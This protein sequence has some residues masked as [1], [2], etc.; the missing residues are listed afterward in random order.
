[1]LS[2]HELAQALLAG[3]DVRIVMQKDGEG[4]SYSPFADL[5]QAHYRPHNVWDGW[6]YDDPHDDAVPCIVLAPNN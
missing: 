1:M 3:P 4:N 6:V 5:R 2:A